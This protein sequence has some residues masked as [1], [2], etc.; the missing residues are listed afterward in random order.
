MESLRSQIDERLAPVVLVAGTPAAEAILAN[1]NGVSIVDLLRPQARVAGMNGAPGAA[2]RGRGCMHARI[3]SEQRAACRLTQC[4][5]RAAACQLQQEWQHWRKCQST[6]LDPSSASVHRAGLPFTTIYCLFSYPA[7][8][9]RVGEFST[10]VTEL[11]LRL[12]P[13]TS[14][15]Q[16][17]P[18]VRRA[19]P[20]ELPGLM[21]VLRPVVKRGS[22]GGGGI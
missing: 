13:Y 5:F 12:V 7:V 10:R 15:C 17:T 1:A 22:G 16:P 4:V 21:C 11:P 19:V 18:E 6:R 3:R 20:Q 9:I 8:P 14:A 2:G